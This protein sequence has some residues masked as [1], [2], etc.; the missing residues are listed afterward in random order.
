METPK[1]EI[2]EFGGFTLDARKRLLCDA[3]GAKIA[4]MPKVFDTLVFLVENAGKVVSKD[5]LL[6]TIWADTIVEE[7]NLTQNISSLRRVFG[8]KPGEHRFISTIPGRGYKFVAEVSF[9]Q[10]A[11]PVRETERAEEYSGESNLEEI[12]SG[13]TGSAQGAPHS[14]ASSSTRPAVVVASLL[15]GIIVFAGAYI[16]WTRNTASEAPIRSIAVLPFTNSSQIPDGEYLSDGISENVINGLSRL[17]GIKVMSRNSTFRFRGDQ[18]NIREIGSQL[19]V[20]AVITGDVRQVGSDFVINVSLID[21][22]DDRHIWGN[23]YRKSS[24]DLIG[25]QNE[26]AEAV[27]KNLRLKLTESDARL[28][29]KRDTQNPEA[30]QLYQRGRFHVFRLTPSEVKKGIDYF[31]QAIEIDPTYALAYSGV[32][33]A[34]RS[35]AIGSEMSP[36]EHLSRSKAAAI[37]AIELDESLSEGHSSLG[38]T[39]FWGDWDWRAAEEDYRRALELN[40]SNTMAHLFYAHLLSN[41]GRHAE[42]AAEMKLARELDPL[43]PFGNALEG[44]FLVHAGQTDA[45]LQQLQKTIELAPNFWMP[46]L[47][48][49][50][51]YTEKGMYAEAIA[52]AQ[53]AT[54]FSPAQTVSIAFEGYALARSGQRA[55]AQANLDKLLKLSTERFVP[56]THIAIVY[57]GLGD[58]EKALEWLEKGFEQ[59]DP[60]MTFLKVEPKWANLRSEPRFTELIRRLNLE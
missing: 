36:V 42:A 15:L 35:L 10:T 56:A 25:A 47:F 33:D 43:F 46:H 37:R 7:N 21:A 48:A 40:P 53:R 59:R 49:S 22:R 6:A 34:Y 1:N 57:C 12:G 26:I 45:G 51:A 52:S 23:Q 30:W 14:P 20:D 50:S 58:K 38:M 9:R 3:S 16:L 41:L 39:I 17:A 27:A 24:T 28:L 55:K 5:E 18:A 60:K 29:A 13:P 11:S 8:E 54:E 31:E 2:F 19:A 4:L 32:S 44:Q